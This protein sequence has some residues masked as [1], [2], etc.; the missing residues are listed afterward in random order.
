[1]QNKQQLLSSNRAKQL[2]KFYYDKGIP[3]VICRGT[4]GSDAN[5]HYTPA[6]FWSDM[7]VGWLPQ[8]AD[9]VNICQ[10]CKLATA[11]VS[12]FNYVEEKSEQEQEFRDADCLFR[13]DDDPDTCRSPKIRQLSARK[14]HSGKANKG[15]TNKS[16]TKTSKISKNGK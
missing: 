2:Y 6:P 1:M 7:C 13:R 4:S 8:R 14:K 12:H 16:K 5:F 15:V 11:P 9:G 10:Y 3:A